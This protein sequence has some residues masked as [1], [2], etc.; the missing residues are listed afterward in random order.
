VPAEVAVGHPELGA[1]EREV[2]PSNAGQTCQD[3][4][5]NPLVDVVVKPMDRVFCH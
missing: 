5:P 2:R 3:A 1:Q 4:E